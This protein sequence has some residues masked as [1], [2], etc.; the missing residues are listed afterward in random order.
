MA[1]DRIGRCAALATAA[2][3]WAVW[4]LLS[5][6][7]VSFLLVL[8]SELLRRP[9]LAEDVV[10]GVV[11]ETVLLGATAWAAFRALRRL[12][13]PRRF[14]IS[15]PA[16]YVLAF[17]AYLVISRLAGDTV[18]QAAPATALE[19]AVVSIVVGAAA[20]LGAGGPREAAPAEIPGALEH[21]GADAD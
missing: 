13:P 9:Q 15:A 7:P 21:L 8:A 14:W 1:E 18:I 2:F 19:V 5:A 20:F 6:A 17:A 4:C 11:V 16:G 12:E 10:A 3:A